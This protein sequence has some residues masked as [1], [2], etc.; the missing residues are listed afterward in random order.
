MILKTIELSM[1]RPTLNMARS[2]RS[3]QKS[4]ADILIPA[5]AF[6]NSKIYNFARYLQST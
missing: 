3:S 1:V 5:R 4:L 6:S 2:D